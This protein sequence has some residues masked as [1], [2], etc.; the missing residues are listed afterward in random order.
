MLNTVKKLKRT[1]MGT[2]KRQSSMYC[3]KY[4]SEAV[5]FAISLDIYCGYHAIVK[6]TS[7]FLYKIMNVLIYQ[8]STDEKL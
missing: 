4:L 8:R 3:I 6:S 1:K 5:N 2:L 7:D